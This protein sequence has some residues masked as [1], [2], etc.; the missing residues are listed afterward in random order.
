MTSRFTSRSAEEAERAILEIQDQRDGNKHCA[1]CGTT[2]PEFINLTIG[3][4]LCDICADIHRTISKRIVKDIYSGELSMED[5]RRMEAVGN[6]VANRKFLAT[7]NPREVP[8]PNRRDRDQLREFLWLKYDG[9]FKKAPVAPPPAAHRPPVDQYYT[10]RPPTDHSH[11]RDNFYKKEQ[12]LFRDQQRQPNLQ[13]NYWSTRFGQQPQQ[14]PP[15]PIRRDEYYSQRPPAPGPDRYRAMP[16]AQRFQAPQAPPTDAFA[17]ARPSRPRYREDVYDP[18]APP[19]L[20]NPAF[21]RRMPA[22]E[23][24]R[25]P[26]Y[27]PYTYSDEEVQRERHSRKK[28]SKS[29]SKSKSKPSRSSVSKEEYYSEDDD[30][31]DEEEYSERRSKKSQSKKSKKKSSRSSKSKRRSDQANESDG[32]E[33]EYEYDGEDEDEKRKPTR[34]SSKSEKRSGKEEREDSVK[35]LEDGTVPAKATNA[36]SEFDLMSEWMG[37]SKETESPR[38]GQP[39]MTGVMPLPNVA[40]AMHQAYQTAQIPMMAPPMSMYGSVMPMPG[41]GLMPMMPPGMVPGMAPPGMRGMPPMPPGMMGLGGVPG[42]PNMPPMQVPGM[43]L[44]QNMGI[45]AQ[46]VHAL[47]NGMQHMNVHSSA[48]SG[49]QGPTSDAPPPPPPVG[50]PAGPAPGPPSEPPRE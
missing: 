8:E 26:S 27:D 21:D 48:T 20:P 34:K 5:V 13:S 11:S 25:P 4:F 43:P 15:P 14:L 18:R 16:Q 36:R 17:H 6:D 19:A 35:S 41:G 23:Q 45:P 12:D 1:D 50:M 37:D 31:S 30:E 9:S 33:D 42:A 49:S 44:A 22:V 46:G 40:Q 10:Q 24:Q 39:A 29:K 38:G 32:Y 28:P 3:T 2:R 7:W 47:T